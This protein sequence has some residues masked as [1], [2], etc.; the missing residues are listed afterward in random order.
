[1][2]ESRKQAIISGQLEVF[3]GMTDEELREVYYLETNV[4]GDLP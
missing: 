2:V 1:M 3:P 4:I